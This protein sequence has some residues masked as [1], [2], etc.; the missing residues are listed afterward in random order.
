MTLAVY[1]CQ[2]LLQQMYLE[3][4]F[5]KVFACVP[6]TEFCRYSAHMHIRAVEKSENLSQRLSGIVAPFVA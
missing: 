2:A 1:V 5:C 3:S 6:D 4:G